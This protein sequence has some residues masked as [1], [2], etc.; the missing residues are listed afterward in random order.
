MF[1]CAVILL[2]LT[3]LAAC[4]KKEQTQEG[5]LYEIYYV[6]NDETKI[7]K[8]EYVTQSVDAESLFDELTGQLQTRS[9]GYHSIE[10]LCCQVHLSKE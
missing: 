7:V 10:A 3:G 5:T 2:M 1:L 6:N 4:G 9:G 8:R